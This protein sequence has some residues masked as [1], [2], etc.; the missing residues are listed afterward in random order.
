MVNIFKVFNI[1]SAENA[2][3]VRAMKYVAIEET[4]EVPT[5]AAT[6][7]EGTLRFKILINNRFITELT[8]DMPEDKATELVRGIIKHEMD[9]IILGHLVQ[10]DK[11]MNVPK[12]RLKELGFDATEDVKIDMSEEMFRILYN[13]AA[14]SIINTAH[15]ELKDM[16]FV[17]P[18]EAVLGA[19]GFIGA[20]K[21]F[22]ADFTAEDLTAALYLVA[23]NAGK[24][25]QI[26]DL[27]T[28]VQKINSNVA[29]SVA[30]EIT[31]KIQQETQEVAKG[32]ESKFE[33]FTTQTKQKS[34][35]W[36]IVLKQLIGNVLTDEVK[37]KLNRLNK[38]G[39][40]KVV[41]KKQ[42][43]VLALLDTSGSMD[44]P[45]INELIAQLKSLRQI[46]LIVY[47][48]STDV[49]KIDIKQ[50]NI[51]INV[52]GGGTSLI[53]ALTKLDPK[54]L[55][56]TTALVVLTDGFDDFPVYELK[57]IK[58]KKIFVLTKNHNPDFAR[59][60]K[61]YGKVLITN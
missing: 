42:A 48:Y 26:K 6:F 36:T 12:D 16:Q 18:E 24:I 27:A 53:T 38:V 9:H 61:K 47:A 52:R 34:S 22:K 5:A 39:L 31:K 7:D 41:A 4:E 56:N 2:A 45:V 19:K 60:A 58:S 46:Q 35:K 20:T 25:Q 14:D 1:V 40:P 49:E 33:Q 15:D 3:Y 30:K 23:K 11:V 29:K 13:I 21:L 54:D 44:E 59:I 32:Y 17:A 8:A 55:Q 57:K 28:D 51:K 43:K 50:K 10:T 37:V